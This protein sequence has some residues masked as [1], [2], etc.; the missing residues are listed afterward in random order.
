[1]AKCCYGEGGCA[2][3]RCVGIK[4]VLEEGDAEDV[5]GS[6]NAQPK[7]ICRGS[8]GLSFV[9]RSHDYFAGGVHHAAPKRPSY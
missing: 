5:Q 8:H 9:I 4:I 6:G 1:M 3:F 2:A 7:A